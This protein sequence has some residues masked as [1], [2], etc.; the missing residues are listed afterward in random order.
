MDEI[1]KFEDQVAALEVT[2]T[3]AGAVTASFS[4][5]VLKMQSSIAATSRETETLSKGLSKGLRSA[6]DGLVFDGYRASDALGA[7]ARS[8]VDTVYAAAIRPVT[9]H[10]GGLIAQGVTGLFA[11]GAAFS[12]GKVTPFASGGIVSSPTAFPMRG[13]LGVMGE[14]GPEA[15]MPLSR[16]ADGKLGVRMEGGGQP[17]SIVMNISTPD[18]QSFQRSQSQIAAHLTRALGRGDRNR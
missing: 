10:L 2:L 11:N 1:D 9:T 14:A 12:Q 3:E 16:G 8:L 18:A 6:F 5:E 17:V 4:D 13:G 15:I 7:V